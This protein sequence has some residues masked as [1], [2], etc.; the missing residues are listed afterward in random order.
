MKLL[1]ELEKYF[2]AKVLQLEYILLKI[3]ENLRFLINETIMKI[4]I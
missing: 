1:D 4:L 3:D 2:E